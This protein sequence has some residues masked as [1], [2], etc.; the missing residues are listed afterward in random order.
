MDDADRMQ[1]WIAAVRAELDV[2]PE[3][4]LDVAALLDLARVA[5]HGVLRPAAPLTTFLVGYAAGLA[6]GSDDD[7][8]R[9]IS[10]IAAIAPEPPPADRD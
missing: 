1:R 4:E 8:A 9:A 10:R 3:L 2:P 5:A 6:G 7:V